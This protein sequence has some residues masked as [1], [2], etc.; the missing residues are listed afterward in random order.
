M[1]L[2]VLFAWYKSGAID[3]YANLDWL[4]SVWLLL[5]GARVC[6]CNWPRLEWPFAVDSRLRIWHMRLLL[7]GWNL[8]RRCVG[9][10]T[11]F[12]RA[13]CLILAGCCIQLGCMGTRDRLL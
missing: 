5:L 10:C 12:V 11:S 2:L 4:Y 8:Q 6:A 13:W 7:A 1:P 3:R 9:T